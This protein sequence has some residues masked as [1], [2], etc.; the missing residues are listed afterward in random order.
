MKLLEH[1]GNEAYILPWVWSIRLN[2]EHAQRPRVSLWCLDLTLWYSTSNYTSLEGDG[3]R[4]ATNQT[5]ETEASVWR[6][7][8]DSS[9]FL[10]RHQ[11]MVRLLLKMQEERRLLCSTNVNSYGTEPEYN[12]TVL[13][14]HHKAFVRFQN[15]LL[16]RESDRV[17]TTTYD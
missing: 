4:E 7:L 6:G 14:N 12:I 5:P 17:E 11:H 10:S 13:H 16:W 3:N 9:K 15:S 8:G 1:S 2:I